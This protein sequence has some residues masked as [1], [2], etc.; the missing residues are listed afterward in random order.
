MAEGASFEPRTPR[1]ALLAIRAECRGIHVDSDPF[2]VGTLVDRLAEDGLRPT[3]PDTFEY[4]DQ[5]TERLARALH[6]LSQVREEAADVSVLSGE[7]DEA[8]ALPPD[9]EAAVER[10][11]KVRP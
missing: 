11:Q 9:I 5:L 2:E 1:E 8:L 10:Y 3:R 7:I 4:T 6:L